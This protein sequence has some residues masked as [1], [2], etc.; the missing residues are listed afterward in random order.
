MTAAPSPT[1]SPQILRREDDGGVVTLT[2]TQPQNRNALGLRMID[3]LIV[4][5]PTSPGTR[6]AGHRSR[7]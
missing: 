1:P 6:G 5:W 4:A 7:G 2:L 3:A